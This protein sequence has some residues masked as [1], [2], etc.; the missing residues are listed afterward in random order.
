MNTA[1]LSLLDLQEIL[2]R[3]DRAS[4][5]EKARASRLRKSIEPPVLEHLYH[6]LACNRRSVA[7]VR[8]GVCGECH[9][10]LP[11]A[12]LYEL[13]NSDAVPFCENCGCFVA[14]AAD[15]PEGVHPGC[16]A[17]AVALAGRPQ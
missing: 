14:L 5:A 3:G 13:R 16:R 17:P 15:E 8:N 4:S 6:Q 2:R 7:L 11:I 9:I 1:L 10:R 12:V